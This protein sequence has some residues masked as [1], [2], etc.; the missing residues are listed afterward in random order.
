[1]KLN[2]LAV[3]LTGLGLSISAISAQAAANGLYVGAGIGQSNVDYT[4][5]N[6]NLSPGDRSDHS[7]LAWTVN[8]GYQLNPNF[9]LQMD[10]IDYHDAA[11]KNILGVL[12]AKATYQQG[13]LDF[14]G[15]VMYPFGNGFNIF[16]TGGLA[17]VSL[18]R[19]TNSTAKAA[20]ITLNDK[21]NIRPTYG[22]GAGYDFYPGWSALVSWSQIPSGGSI[23]TSNY[24][25]AGVAYH[26]G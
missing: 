19:S 23:E 9:A 1:M 13:A 15:K 22:V 6:Q 16:A 21:D 10:Y 26:F 18:D 3:T 8:G 24:F 12:D 2:K 11:F 20:G 17:Y 7:G 25:G 5:S 14:V 4:V